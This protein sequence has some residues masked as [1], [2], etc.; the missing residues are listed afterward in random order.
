MADARREAIEVNGRRYRWPARPLVVVCVDGCEP[1]YLDAARCAPAPCPGWRACARAGR[2]ALA[3][4]VMPSF[5]NP[6]QPLDRH[7]RAARGARHLRQLLLRSRRRRRSDD[8]RPEVSA[9]RHDPRRARRAGAHVAVVTAKD[10]LRRLLGHGLRGRSA[11]R[12]RRPTRRRSPSTASTTCSSCVGARCRRCTAPSSASS[13]SPRACAHGARRPDVMYLSTTDY[14][15]HKHAPGTPAANAFYRMMDGYLRA[16]D[17]LGATIA[18]TADHG[19]NAKTDAAGAPQVD[20]PAGRARRLARRGQGARDPADHRSLRR[21]PRRAG[22]VRHGLPAGRA[23]TPARRGAAR[24][25]CRASRS[26]WTRA[27]GLRALRA[28]APT[29]WATSSSS[30]RGTS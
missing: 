6:E 5:T 26:C 1:D 14:V 29:G 18:L 10:K 8:E 21:P 3:D 20:L 4:C 25:R 17:A 22:L 27:R 16:L 30:P 19:M 23:P 7:R 2:T 15:Q 9:R 12:R 24:A 11:S 28:A 13:S